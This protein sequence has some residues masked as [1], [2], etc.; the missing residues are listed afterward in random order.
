MCV[1]VCVCVC[2]FARVC[3]CVCKSPPLNVALFFT[4]NE[5]FE[6]V[7]NIPINILPF[8]HQFL[9]VFGDLFIE[10]PYASRLR[11]LHAGIYFPNY[12]L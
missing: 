10:L 8:L 1:C 9:C 11:L 4:V 12:G 7:F 2:A 3:E 6:V 5:I